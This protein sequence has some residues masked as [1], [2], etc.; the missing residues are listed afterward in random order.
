M[1]TRVSYR[2]FTYITG[3]CLMYFRQGA[4]HR[5]YK[6]IIGLANER[7]FINKITNTFQ[8]V[9]DYRLFSKTKRGFL[10]DQKKYYAFFGDSHC[11]EHTSADCNC[12]QNYLKIVTQPWQVHEIHAL[13]VVLVSK[14]LNIIQAIPITEFH[15]HFVSADFRWL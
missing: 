9:T 8:F 14:D 2:V 3:I 1:R 5:I 6:Q 13:K 4:S 11:Y 12:N 15:A 7:K 10:K